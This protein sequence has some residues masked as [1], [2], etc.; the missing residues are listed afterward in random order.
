VGLLQAGPVQ[1]MVQSAAV[2]CWCGDRLI[3]AKQDGKWT[4]WACVRPACFER[5]MAWS[6]TT[7]K[8]G[9]V[10]QWLFC[11]VPKQVEFFEAT[12]RAS[13]VLFGG[14]A[15]PGK[16]HA[17]R[18]G[19]YRDA[20][21]IPNLNCLLLRRT[22]K[23]LDKTHLREMARE[24]PALGGRYLASEKRAVFPNGSLIEAGHCETEID[25]AAYLS[26]EYDRE[27]FD[28]LVTFMRDAALEIM[29][30]ARTSKPQ[31]IAEGGAQ[32]WAGSNPGGRGALWVKSFFV[33]RVVDPEE[34]PHYDAG[35]YAYVGAKLADNPY[36]D[37]LYRQTLEEMPALRRRQLLEGDWL[38]FEGQFFDFLTTKNEQPW[39][40]ADVGVVA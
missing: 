36:I 8:R 17:L 30:R 28:E 31:V 13:R 20:L 33:D 7:M 38:A 11:P 21:R 29:S 10:D 16:S 40:V 12:R 27:V 4:P 5:Q 34:F 6:V 15:G 39:H 14:A 9:A 35:R 2:C 26:A 32:V 1:E 3:R 23:E 19:L 37:P 18:W 25:A 22:Y 24:V